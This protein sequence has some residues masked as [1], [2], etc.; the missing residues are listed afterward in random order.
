MSGF[1]YGVLVFNLVQIVNLI[2]TLDVLLLAFS[3]RLMM[4]MMMMM[5]MMI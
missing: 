5:M 3:C 2:C 4:M 1:E